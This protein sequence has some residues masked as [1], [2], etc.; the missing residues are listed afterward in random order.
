MKKVGML[1]TTVLLLVFIPIVLWFLDNDKELEVVIIDK[2]VPD[3]SFREHLGISWVLNFF[4]Y[5]KSDGS[6]YEPSA[7]YFGYI[8][9]EGEQ[10]D[11]IRPFPRSYDQTDVLYLADTYGVYKEDLAKKTKARQ[12]SR[13]SLIYGGLQMEEWQP[14]LKRL[15][16]EKPLT[17]IAEF[18]SLASPTSEKVRDSMEEQLQLD[19]SGWTGRYFAELNPKINQEIPRWVM[20]RD[21]GSWKYRGPGFILVKESTQEVLVLQEGKHFSGKGIHMKFTEEGNERFGLEK[22]ADYAYWFDIVTPKNKEDVLAYYDWNLTGDGK[23]LLKEHQIPSLF[24]GV[25]ETHHNRTTSYYFAGDFNDMANMPSVY[26]FKGFDWIKKIASANSEE[27]FF[28]QTYVPMM[29]KILEKA[30]RKQSSRPS[31]QPSEKSGSA[32]CP[33]RVSGKTFEVRKGD[34][35]KKLRIKGV[36]IGMG[37]PGAFPGE[38]AITEEE[39]YRWL[40]YIGDMGANA[41]RVYTLHP[42]AFYQAL[43]RYNEAHQEPIYLFHGVWIDEGSLADTLDA[44][45]SQNTQVF[46]KEMKQIA[47]VIHGNAYVEP[48]AGHA[49]GS[50]RADISPYVI[51][52]II[53]IEWYPHMVQ[54]TNNKHEGI[55]DYK[56]NYFETKQ[57][58]PFEHWLAKQMDTLISYEKKTYQSIRPV[59]FTN[60]VTTDLLDHPSEPHEEEDL[61]S[62]NPNVIQVKHD[63]KKVNQFASYHVY[64]YYPDFMNYEEDYLNYKDHRGRFNSYAAYLRDLH[65]AHTMPVLIAEFGLPASRG[66]THE[67]SFGYNQGLLSE[68]QQGKLIAELYEDIVQEGML[69]GLI[70]TWQDEWFKR[71]WNTMDYDNPD[72]RPFWSNAQTSEQQFGLLSFDRHKIK[73]DGQ[74]SDWKEAAPLYKESRDLWVDHDE[75]YLY[76]RIHKSKAQKGYPVILLNTVEGQGNHR[77]ASIRGLSFSDG[78]DFLIS[79]PN[80]KESRVLVDAYYDFFT[81]QYG[82]KLN[83]LEP[84]PPV[85]VKNSGI[86]HPQRLALNKELLIPKTGE[87][88]PFSAYETGRLRHGNANPQAADYDS[89]ADYRINDAANVIEVRIP[90]L[91][92]NVK[93]PSQREVMGDFYRKGMTSSAK[94]DGIKAGLVWVKNDQAADSLPQMK[95][96][97]MPEMNT[98][99]WKPWDQPLYKERLKA[100]YDVIKEAFQKDR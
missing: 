92:L 95:N 42:P 51:G 91:L 10:A 25:I 94:T 65:K 87:R 76:F 28:W 35:W 33:S 12:G 16:A 27:E 73:V 20:N 22:S 66:M 83:M 53:G 17:F 44:F 84:A 8:P 3:E 89:L 64:P 61:V 37:K 30:D 26:R 77:A 52:W 45:A 98:Y 58:S 96:G 7:D 57:A 40:T 79:L 60:W 15:N 68:K 23:R 18:N 56:G 31:S 78:V 59:S 5:R 80:R 29:K 72:R 19:W 21:S 81:Y 63:M 54:G 36:N 46:Q 88:I 49:S 24:A 82:I 47:D 74:V 70:F 69:G 50:Y 71:T 38:A 48:S 1:I 14:I 86:F 100:S 62:V 75:R 67:N 34:D 90:W 93:D 39:Y 11:R 32:V 9:N 97:K 99:S 85:P 41:I 43:K 2:T 6:K 4:G 55:G 13:S